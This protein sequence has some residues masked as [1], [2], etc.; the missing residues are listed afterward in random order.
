VPQP[1]GELAGDGL[2][3]GVG[4]AD[5]HAQS[6]TDAS[7]LLARDRDRRLR[8]SLDHGTHRGMLAYHRPSPAVTL[9]R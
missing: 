8:H 1:V 5:Q 6:G 4:D 9:A 7:D 2:V 3:V